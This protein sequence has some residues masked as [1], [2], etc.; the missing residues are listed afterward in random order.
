MCTW[1]SRPVQADHTLVLINGSNCS[2]VSNASNCPD[3]PS[4]GDIIPYPV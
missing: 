3:I 4:S 1:T 2:N